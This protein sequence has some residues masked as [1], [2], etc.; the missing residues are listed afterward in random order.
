M[1]FRALDWD[2]DTEASLRLWDAEEHKKTYVTVLPV[3]PSTYNDD[4]HSSWLMRNLQKL[5]GKDV[6]QNPDAESFV[7]DEPGWCKTESRDN[8]RIHADVCLHASLTAQSGTYTSLPERTLQNQQD[9][10]E[11]KRFKPQETKKEAVRT[12]NSPTGHQMALFTKL[13]IQATAGTLRI[14]NEP[15]NGK[16]CQRSREPQILCLNMLTCNPV[17]IVSSGAFQPIFSRIIENQRLEKKRLRKGRLFDRMSGNEDA[18][19]V[20]KRSKLSNPLQSSFAHVNALLPHRRS[21]SSDFT[22]ISATCAT[23]TA[24]LTRSQI[25]RSSSILLRWAIQLAMAALQYD[26]PNSRAIASNTILNSQTKISC[27]GESD[28]CLNPIASSSASDTGKRSRDSDAERKRAKKERRVDKQV[29]REKKRKRKEERERRA[30][31]EMPIKEP[32]LH[33]PK[34]D[35]EGKI[36]PPRAKQ[37]LEA[38][39][40]QN[41]PTNTIQSTFCM[42]TSSAADPQAFQKNRAHPQ[43]C[44]FRQ[45][46]E[47]GGKGAASSV[48]QALQNQEKFNHSRHKYTQVC[49]DVKQRTGDQSLPGLRS[50]STEKA[51]S[52]TKGCITPVRATRPKSD[53]TENFLLQ[54]RKPHDVSNDSSALKLLQRDFSGHLLPNSGSTSFELGKS[55]MTENQPQLAA[56]VAKVDM[57]DAFE[58][59]GTDDSLFVNLRQQVDERQEHQLVPHSSVLNGPEKDY[60]NESD[61]IHRLEP[62]K[63]L[64]SESFFEDWGEAVGQLL[65]GRWAASNVYLSRDAD[66]S[67]NFYSKKEVLGR[68]IELCDSP[69]VDSREVDIELSDRCAML[70]YPVSAFAEESNARKIVFGLAEITAVDRYRHIYI[71]ICYDVSPTP[72]I[73]QTLVRAQNSV[74]RPQ[75]DSM[76]TSFKSVASRSLAA[77]LAETIISHEAIHSARS[78]ATPVYG[79][80]GEGDARQRLLFLLSICQTAHHAEVVVQCISGI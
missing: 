30:L 3:D 71:F 11:A 54:S 25:T 52:V 63:I 48:I 69:L 62:L 21:S 20:S 68:K 37:T 55:S 31:F 74:W 38:R 60:F 24:I 33:S 29:K 4:D 43:E 15:W 66:D 79:L 41:H 65:S 7:V 32:V 36:N 26:L 1:K 73:R 27:H 47:T 61:T 59:T 18:K 58:E 39:A 50:T 78:L 10:E 28:F 45:P 53:D 8:C 22:D 34:R 5:D 72:A 77:R 35:A 13:S 49:I 12:R 17:S 9:G 6:L 70:V 46:T 51:K 19:A 75:G 56:S 14:A 67:S 44:T 80:V 57:A 42:L 40:S 76:S 64:C 2:Y 16:I 23:E